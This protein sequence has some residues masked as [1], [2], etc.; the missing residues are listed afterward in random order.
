MPGINPTTSS[1]SESLRKQGAMDGSITAANRLPLS[2]LNVGTLSCDNRGGCP[3]RDDGRGF[4]PAR[5][6]RSIEQIIFD[7]DW[8]KFLRSAEEIN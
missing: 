1:L 6:L 4:G 5:T 2:G 3:W 7:P 8:D